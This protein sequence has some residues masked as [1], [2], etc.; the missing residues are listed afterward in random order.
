M[1]EV[2]DLAQSQTGDA[3]L[4]EFIKKSTTPFELNADQ[5]I[6]LKDIG[7]SEQVLAALVQRSQE[8]GAVAAVQP[9]PW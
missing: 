6:Y 3:V 2:V 5:I 9:A 1:A 4:L 7:I 8:L